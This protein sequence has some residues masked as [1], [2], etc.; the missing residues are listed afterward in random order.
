M[1]KKSESDDSLVI[2]YLGLRKAIGIIGLALPFALAAGKIIFD[3]GGLQSSMSAYYHT[4]HAESFRGKFVRDCGLPDVL[5]G[6]RSQRQHHRK[7]SERIRYRRRFLSDLPGSRCNRGRRNDRDEFTSFPRQASS[8][9]S[10]S[11]RC[12]SFAKQIRRSA[13]HRKNESA[14]WSIWSAV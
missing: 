3:G 6:P 14:T 7:N 2:S 4:N 9:R 11:S 12:F 5:L 13:R 1:T 8:L 10:H